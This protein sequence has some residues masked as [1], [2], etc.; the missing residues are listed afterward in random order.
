MG[1][2]VTRLILLLPIATFAHRT[3]G[4]HTALQATLHPLT[5]LDHLLALLAIGW[6]AAHARNLRGRLATPAMFLAGMTAGF[7]LGLSGFGAPSTEYAIAL[8][9]IALGGLIAFAVES[10][11]LWMFTLGA[12]VCHGMVHGAE[13]PATA[14]SA[15][16]LGMLLAGSTALLLLGMQAHL[17][18]SRTSFFP[19]IRFATSAL[20]I[21][22][23]IHFLLGAA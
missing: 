4:V 19:A 1:F 6:L 11:H 17:F 9:V 22:A 5:G 7:C 23:G 3:P 13:M 18:T 15:Q 20:L 14:G 21:A 8:S 2:S 10:R 12:G 16:Y